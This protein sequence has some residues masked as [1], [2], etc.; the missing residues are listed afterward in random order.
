MIKYVKS[1]FWNN[2]AFKIA[3]ICSDG[4]HILRFMH[5]LGMSKLSGKLGMFCIAYLSLVFDLHVMY[6]SDGRPP[7][8][9]PEWPKLRAGILI[10]Y[11]EIR[12]GPLGIPSIDIDTSV[13]KI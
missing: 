4:H 11:M 3:L 10:F 1:T 5:P 2:G 8:T 12:V 7:S 6:T 9:R 13:T